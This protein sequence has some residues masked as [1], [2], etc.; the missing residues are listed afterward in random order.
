MDNHRLFL[1]NLFLN[2]NYT[3][4]DPNQMEDL[5]ESTSSFSSSASQGV[6]QK[7]MVR[8]QHL[9]NFIELYGSSKDANMP[10]QSQGSYK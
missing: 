9:Q 5:Q 7:Y 10:S 1:H 6:H 8:Q 3:E 4:I 2:S